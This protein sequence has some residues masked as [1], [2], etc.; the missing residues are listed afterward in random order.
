[1]ENLFDIN[2]CENLL[3][4]IR[5]KL[6][7]IPH[8]GQSLLYFAFHPHFGARSVIVSSEK[9]NGVIIIIKIIKLTTSHTIDS[10]NFISLTFIV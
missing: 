7:V 5:I 1:M 3:C 6:V 8:S 2:A 9:I 4:E 10:A